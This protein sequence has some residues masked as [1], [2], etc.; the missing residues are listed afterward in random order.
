MVFSTNDI[1]ITGY[2]QE[3]KK[4]EIN[5]NLTSLESEELKSVL[6]KVKEE[7][8]KVGLKLNIQKTKIMAPGPIT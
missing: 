1:V 3:K 7:S 2:S 8:G 5:P 6:R 4:R